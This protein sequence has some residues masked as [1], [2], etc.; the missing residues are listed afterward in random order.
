M[1]TDLSKYVTLQELSDLLYIKAPTIRAWVKKGLLPDGAVLTLG[2]THRFDHELII[3]HMSN[4]SPAPA[5]AAAVVSQRK[6]HATP[7]ALND[8]NGDITND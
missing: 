6:L 5:A 3:K 4:K 8:I 2:R 7:V 1:T